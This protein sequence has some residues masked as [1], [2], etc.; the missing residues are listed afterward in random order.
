[1]SER[2]IDISAA[3]RLACLGL[4]QM[5]FLGMR[6]S[7]AV[8]CGFGDKIEQGRRAIRLHF[9]VSRCVAARQ[10]NPNNTDGAE[11]LAS[12][13]AVNDRGTIRC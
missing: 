3:A 10:A 11:Y 9:S 5:G 6:C 12:L 7:S 1:M 4:R 8:T 13:D 2:A